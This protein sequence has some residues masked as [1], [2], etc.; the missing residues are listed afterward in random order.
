MPSLPLKKKIFSILA[1]TP[2]KEKLNFSHSAL[3]HMK[4]RNCLKYFVRGCSSSHIK[5]CQSLKRSAIS[6]NSIT[7]LQKRLRSFHWSLIEI[8]VMKCFSMLS[9]KPNHILRKNKL[10]SSQHS[11]SDCLMNHLVSINFFLN[12]KRCN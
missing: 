10:Q 7:V 5:R 12:M 6:N 2:W 4:T 3:F 8:F 9:Q 1:K 11:I